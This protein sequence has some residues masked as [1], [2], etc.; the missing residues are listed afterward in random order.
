M[1]ASLEC[2]VSQSDAFISPK[3]GCGVF[4]RPNRELD[5]DVRVIHLTTQP[6][7]SISHSTS[8][9]LLSSRFDCSSSSSS[10]SIS[11][12]SS[13]ISSSSDSSGR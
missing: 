10:S 12:Y 8:S 1:A 9:G 2:F 7:Y 11:S 13:D 3:I 5:L 6:S 4:K